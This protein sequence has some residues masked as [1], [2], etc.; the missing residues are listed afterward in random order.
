MMEV[1]AMKEKLQML[2]GPKGI[3]IEPAADRDA[4]RARLAKYLIRASRAV[5][6]SMGHERDQD[7]ILQNDCIWLCDISVAV[8]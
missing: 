6:I 3:E 4:R 5:D 2:L 8:L 1:E 7:S